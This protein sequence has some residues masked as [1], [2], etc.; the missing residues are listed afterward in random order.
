MW[1]NLYEYKYIHVNAC[2]FF[3]NICCM[4]V[5]LY[6][7]NKYTQYTHKLCKQKLLCWMRLITINHLTALIIVSA[8]TYVLKNLLLRLKKCTFNTN[9]LTYFTREGRRQVVVWSRFTN[10]TNQDSF[11]WSVKLQQWETV[12]QM[13]RLFACVYSTWLTRTCSWIN[14][15]CCSCNN[16]L[17]N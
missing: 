8:S 1:Y 13:L 11:Q 4:C 14:I 5:S 7:N 3:P 10:L 12:N 16:I 15:F 6:I 2:N 17:V 9:K